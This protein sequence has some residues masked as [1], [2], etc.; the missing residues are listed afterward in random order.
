[1]SERKIKIESLVKYPV[2]VSI[3]SMHFSRL[4]NRELQSALI[5][6]DIIEEGLQQ[7]S[8][9]YYIYNGILRVV[10]KQDR[11]DL[12]LEASAEEEEFEELPKIVALSTGEMI[13][14]MKSK[15]F[16]K[17]ENV[18]KDCSEDIVNR[19]IS[20]A[21]GSKIYDYEVTSLL[22]KYSPEGTN[23]QKLIA[24]AEDAAKP[25]MVEEE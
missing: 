4:F 23:I 24:L 9:R 11:I 1:M 3:P 20:A 21:I 13:T 19:F 22:Q 6:Y 10:D 17:L 14:L 15:D 12:G 18:L 7:S 16:K 25:V 8:F 2:S 5:D